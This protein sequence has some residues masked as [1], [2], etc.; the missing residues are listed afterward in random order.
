MRKP[1]L[2]WRLSTL[3]VLTV[4]GALISWLLVLPD[5]TL[6]RFL[7]A[8]RHGDT[9]KMDLMLSSE[10]GFSFRGMDDQLKQA[11]HLIVERGFDDYFTGKIEF[12][13]FIP[14]GKMP[15]QL[16]AR[17]RFEVKWTKIRLVYYES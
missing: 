1:K 4:L 17:I 6:G 14:Y 7:Q 8:A 3:L 10:S 2:R 9:A 13:T 5:R 12:S 16:D 11:E 15:G